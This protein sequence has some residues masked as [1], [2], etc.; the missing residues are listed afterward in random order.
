MVQFID[1][2]Y[3]FFESNL[4]INNLNHETGFGA[5]TLVKFNKLF[6]EVIIE[7]ILCNSQSI[8]GPGIIVQIDETLV[9]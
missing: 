2:P 5:K 7:H 3:F 6:R 8:D 4:N 1:F 9:F